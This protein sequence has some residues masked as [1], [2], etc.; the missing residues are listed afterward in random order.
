MTDYELCCQDVYNWANNLVSPAAKA[1]FVEQHPRYAE[2]TVTDAFYWLRHLREEDSPAFLCLRSGQE[3]LWFPRRRYAD[4]QRSALTQI[5]HARRRLDTLIKDLEHAAGNDAIP[6]MQ[7][8]LRACYRLQA[9][10]DGTMMMAEQAVD[11]LVSA[12]GR[13]DGS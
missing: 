12:T 13:H 4:I 1:K 9:I 7:S 2:Q 10:L 11:S 6:M 5:R 8:E 3:Q